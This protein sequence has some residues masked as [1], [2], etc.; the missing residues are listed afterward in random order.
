[1]CITCDIIISI[2]DELVRPCVLY[3][4]RGSVS[5]RRYIRTTAQKLSYVKRNYDLYLL[6]IPALAYIIVFHY[7]P[8]FGIV[9][10]FEKYNRRAIAAEEDLRACEV[11]GVRVR[12]I[13]SER[14]AEF[15]CKEDV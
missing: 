15:V 2:L 7:L 1:M 3:E 5:V 6:L 11:D 8:M 9:I 10:A 13:M 4:L 12:N 14:R